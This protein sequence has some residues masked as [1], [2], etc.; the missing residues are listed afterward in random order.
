MVLAPVPELSED[1]RTLTRLKSFLA[2][3]LGVDLAENVLLIAF[4]TI[5]SAA[6]YVSAGTSVS[7]IWNTT[8][9]QLAAVSGATPAASSVSPSGSGNTGGGSRGC[10]G[11]RHNCD[12][13]R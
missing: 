6:V 3:E 1:L 2:D 10:D 5:A 7:G 9:S 13:G 8:S 12:D 11:D 4:V